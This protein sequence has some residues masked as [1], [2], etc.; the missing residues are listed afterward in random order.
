MW[1]GILRSRKY[2]AYHTPDGMRPKESPYPVNAL[3]DAESAAEKVRKAWNLGGGPISNM[4]VLLERHGIKI[5]TLDLPEIGG[6]IDLRRGTPW[7]GTRSRSGLQV[8]D[9]NRIA[10][11]HPGS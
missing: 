11:V 7:Q 2:S 8:R 3:D 10:E 4:T 1:S 5:L 6:W 9:G